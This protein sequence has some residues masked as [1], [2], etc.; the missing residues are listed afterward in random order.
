MLGLPFDIYRLLFQ[1]TNSCA[2]EG[3]TC[4]F[5]SDVNQS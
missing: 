2:I 3:D 1:N 5:G 4:A